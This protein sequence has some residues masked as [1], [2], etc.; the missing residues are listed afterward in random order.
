M[1][2]IMGDD[3]LTIEQAAELLHLTPSTV[4]SYLATGKLQRLKIGCRTRLSR[5]EV[6][7]RVSPG[8]TDWRAFAFKPKPATNPWSRFLALV[9]PLT[10]QR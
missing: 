7:S 1:E 10:H 5:A 4:R 2:G 6:L 9:I 8:R 3:L